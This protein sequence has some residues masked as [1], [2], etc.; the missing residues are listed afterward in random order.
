MIQFQ[1]LRV[2]QAHC[3]QGIRPESNSSANRTVL[4]AGFVDSVRNIL[5]SETDCK[6][7]ASNSS[8]YD[9]DLGLASCRSHD[10]ERDGRF[11]LALWPPEVCI[12][13]GRVHVTNICPGRDGTNYTLTLNMS[14][15]KKILYV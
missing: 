5:S 15:N 10:D 3:T 4:K 1:E 11:L 14:S 13:G 7:K 9:G 2:N 12:L 8:A 6:C